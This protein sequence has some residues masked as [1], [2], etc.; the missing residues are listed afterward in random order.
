M[1]YMMKITSA[2]VTT[3]LL[4]FSIAHAQSSRPQFEVAS[5]KASVPG[6]ATVDSGGVGFVHAASGLSGKNVS[7]K[8]MIETAYHLQDFQISGGPNWVDS[9]MMV[10][11]NRYNVEARAARDATRD[12][13]N[14]MLQA[15]LADRFRLAF[16]REA[17]EMPIYDLVLA[18][19]GPKLKPSEAKNASDSRIR[20]GGGH[21]NFEAS[22]LAELI[23]WL[24]GAA[25]HR[26]ILNKTGLTG[27]FNFTLDYTPETFR[28]GKAPDPTAEGTIDPNG[29]SI[30][31]AL[32]E[33]LG[34]KLESARGPVEV[35]VIDSVQKPTEN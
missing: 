34:L 29:I 9:S 8:E 24:S 19:S 27:R 23:E 22:S 25:G 2:I 28:G 21:M 3:A 14:Q 16:H 15:L 35:L 17:K 4:C 12:E 7:V 20:G 31:T 1:S 26:I 30:F 33:Q 32:Q 5:V 11:D 10:T 6:R 18:K 13:M